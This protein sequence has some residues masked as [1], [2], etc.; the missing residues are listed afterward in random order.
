MKKTFFMILVFGLALGLFLKAHADTINVDLGYVWGIPANSFGASAGQSGIWNEISLGT[1]NSLLDVAGMVTTVDISVSGDTDTGGATLPPLPTDAQLLL[2]DNIYSNVS[3]DWFVQFT[4]L[5]DGLYYIYLYAPSN[6]GV[7]TGIMTVN[8]N[9]IGE[10]SGSTDGLLIDG[11]S[12]TRV[13]TTVSE[14][15]LSLSGTHVGVTANYA[16]LAGVQLSPILTP[17]ANAGLDQIAFNEV[18]LD[19]SESVDLVGT[20]T[21]YEWQLQHRENPTYDRTAEGVNPTVSELEPGF[22]DVILTVTDNNGK[23]DTDEMEL[24]AVGRKGDLDLNGVVDGSDLSQFS[25]EFG[26]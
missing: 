21:T 25:E 3:P 23:T 14:G 5:S 19:G 9:T 1:T 11:V 12:Y 26:K 10:L 15:I 2:Y 4:G 18:T 24:A 22:Y 16:G 8:G 17:F 6:K 7:T 13:Q 20:I